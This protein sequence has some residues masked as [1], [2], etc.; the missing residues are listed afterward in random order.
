MAHNEL[1]REREAQVHA[2]LPVVQATMDP[3]G[4]ASPTRS[5][6]MRDYEEEEEEK[7]K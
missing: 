4:A 5:T 6:K 3:R 7:G 1:Q 2:P